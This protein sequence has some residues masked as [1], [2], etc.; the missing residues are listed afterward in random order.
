MTLSEPIQNA[1]GDGNISAGHGRALMA[2]SDD[3]VRE[4]LFNKIISGGLSVRQ[5]EGAASYFKENGQLPEGE[6][7]EPPKPSKRKKKE[8]KTVDESLERI[9]GRLESALETKVSFSGSHEKGRMTINFSSEEEL[10]RLVAI[11]EL[12]SH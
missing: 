5:S 3:E 2:V 7:I 12:R 1:I 6:V 9:K 4:D 11:L 10:E 8:P